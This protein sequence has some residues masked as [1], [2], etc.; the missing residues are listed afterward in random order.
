MKLSGKDYRIP[1]KATFV[2]KKIGTKIQEYYKSNISPKM[3]LKSYNVRV[4]FWK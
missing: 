3:K 2:D 4:L 1:H